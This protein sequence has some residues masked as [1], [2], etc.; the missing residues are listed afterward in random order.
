MRFLEIRLEY[1]WVHLPETFQKTFGGWL[2]VLFA[3]EPSYLG[4]FLY[5]SVVALSFYFYYAVSIHRG[6]STVYV[7]HPFGGNH[8][9]IFVFLYLFFFFLSTRGGKKD[10]TYIRTGV[11]VVSQP[12]VVTAFATMH[13]VLCLSTCLHFT[14]DKPCSSFSNI[15]TD[16]SSSG[17]SSNRFSALTY[18]EQFIRMLSKDHPW[19]LTT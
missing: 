5:S 3:R 10:K 8:G 1:I 17:S 11:F 14:Y 4:A 7:F 9:G 19:R 18:K 6:S 12:F 2:C 16:S 13:V 15:S